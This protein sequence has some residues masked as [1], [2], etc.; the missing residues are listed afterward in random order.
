VLLNAATAVHLPS[1][2]YDGLGHLIVNETEAATL[3][4]Q[5]LATIEGQK[6]EDGRGGVTDIF[7]SWGVLHVV[8]T[9]GAKGAYFSKELGKG[10]HVPAGV[11]SEVKDATGAG[12]T[13][14]GAYAASAVRRNRECGWDMQ[15]A[16]QRGCRA[17][18]CTIQKLGIQ[19]AILWEDEI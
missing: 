19:D 8:V 1:H 16:V 2:V 13:F 5:D 6:I 3:V 11:I 14:V 17:A 4:Q 18:G 15:E 10:Q 7:L 9:L 12:D